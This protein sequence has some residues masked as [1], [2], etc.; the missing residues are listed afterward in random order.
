MTMMN[1]QPPLYDT[2]YNNLNLTMK[3]YQIYVTSEK[4]Q[5]K[6]SNL[7]ANKKLETKLNLDQHVGEHALFLRR[8]QRI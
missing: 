2:L 8:C 5:K 7:D 1:E 6:K 4:K 3:K